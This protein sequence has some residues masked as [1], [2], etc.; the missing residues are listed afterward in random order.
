VRVALVTHRLAPHQP[1]GVHRYA[2]SLARAL[3][4]N[5]HSGYCVASP[6][7]SPAPVAWPGVP[8]HPL[9]WPR[10]QV[11]LAWSLGGGPLLERGLGDLDLVHLLHPFP[12]VRS[13][14][15]LV[16][17]IPDLTPLDYPS[18]FSARDRLLYRRSVELAVDR[19]Q[20]IVAYS[21]AV[22]A[23]IRDRWRIDAARVTAIPL[24]AGDGLGSRPSDDDVARVCTRHGLTAGS[25]VLHIGALVIRKNLPM[26]VRAAARLPR[27]VT[28]V[29]AG[30]HGNAARNVAREAERHGVSDR[31]RL[32]G[33]VDDGELTALL[34]GAAL[35]AH[36]SH[37]E[38]FGLTL[39]EA[40][41]AGVPVVAARTGAQPEVVGSAGLLLA[42]TDVTGWADAMLRLIES[43]EERERLA[44]AG[45]ARAATF[46]WSRVADATAGV[47][48][49]VMARA[50]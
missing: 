46:T 29:L 42:P 41:C 48:R 25:Y 24:A 26:L 21:E 16:V 44:A 39:L 37:Y 17:T 47:H 22:A 5:G 49:R 27:T 15:P 32:V 36:P 28:L 12:P 31:V 13:R 40:M 43:R 23:A 18:W 11:Q 14:A 33:H 34:A 35:L 50:R 8:Y 9:P 1:T 19:A 20:H 7:E 45:R 10:R 38:G 3:A 30:P 4:G 2:A 6:V